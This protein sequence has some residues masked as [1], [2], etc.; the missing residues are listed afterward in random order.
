[1]SSNYKLKFQKNITQEKSY[2]EEQL[3]VLSAL[4]VAEN[5]FKGAKTAQRL[6]ITK[7]ALSASGLNSNTLF[8]IRSVINR[9]ELICNLYDLLNNLCSCTFLYWHQTL[10]PICFQK[11]VNPK[12]DL[13]SYYVRKTTDTI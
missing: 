13:S 12:H 6:M 4:A 2:K 9:I 1:M 3:D 8:E 7:L 11:L 10:L 5:L